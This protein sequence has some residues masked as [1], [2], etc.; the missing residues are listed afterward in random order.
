MKQLT[1]DRDGREGRGQEEEREGAT[2]Y[3]TCSSLETCPPAHY[4]C[5]HDLTEE[6]GGGERVDS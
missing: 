4:Q 5:E 3:I 1:T 2:V 6:A